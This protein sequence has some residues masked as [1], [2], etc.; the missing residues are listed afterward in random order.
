MNWLDH[1]Y[2]LLASGSLRNF[3]KRNGK[4]N[5][6]CPLCGDS[7]KKASKARGWF[8][9]T[10]DK[11]YY[12]CFNCSASLTFNTFL[13][14][15]NYILWG[16]YILEKFGSNETNKD[17]KEPVKQ[18]IIPK[19]NFELNLTSVTDLDSSHPCKQFVQDRKIPQ[20]FYKTLYFCPKFKMWV[21]TLLPDKFETL[22]Y[23][24][25]RL[26]IPFLD[27]D[28]T[29]FGFQGRSLKPNSKNK[30]ITIML[31]D[32]KQK[33]YG[34]NTY[35]PSKPAIVVEGPIDAMFLS[36]GIAS[37]GGI[38]D[39]SDPC[40]IC[41]DN[42]PR[43]KTTIAKMNRAI[44]NGYTICIW[45][46]TINQKD[47]NDMILAGYS[48]KDLESIIMKNSV[49]DLEAKLKLNAWKKV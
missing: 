37:C 28:K 42:E 47:I 41:Y 21:N 36:N 1:K 34:L 24:E 17:Q 43:S 10:G 38:L 29:F 30:Y 14:Q 49:S 45:P 16:D 26:I 11:T 2:I 32:T 22:D 9:A 3:K 44:K 27:K 8:Y 13:K 18:D 48:S 39:F 23:D 31:D 20:E 40:I 46:E 4:F 35:D 7:K 33:Y 5:C 25:P 15:Q 19:A 6:S 12:H